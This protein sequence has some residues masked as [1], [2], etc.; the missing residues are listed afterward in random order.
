MCF[1]IISDSFWSILANF[2]DSEKKKEIQ[3]GG[4]KM[5]AILEPDVIVT[6]H[7]V[8]SLYADL[9]GDILNALSNL[10]VSLS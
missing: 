2:K 4:S 5:A 10:Q 3:D 7:V 6:S 8:I 1:F 9:K